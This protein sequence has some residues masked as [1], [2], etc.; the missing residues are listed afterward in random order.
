MK[1]V[2]FLIVLASWLIKCKSPNREIVDSFDKVNK[3]IERSDVVNSYSLDHLYL[4]IKTKTDRNSKYLLKADSIYHIA[5]ETISFLEKQK[6]NLRSLDSSGDKLDVAF[7]ALIKWRTADTLENLLEKVYRYSCEM[8]EDTAKKKSIDSVMSS[9]TYLRSNK[10]WK[11]DYFYQTPTIAALTIL[12]KFQSDCK[13]SAVI[14]LS[15][16]YQHMGK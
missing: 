14:T 4:T 12:S 7:G 16:I 3:S 1:N 6:D 11:R 5:N 13:S 2:L 9:V 8:L 10:K 15:D